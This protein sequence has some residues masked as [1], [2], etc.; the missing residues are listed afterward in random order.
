M[1]TIARHR[2]SVNLSFET[3]YAH[4]TRTCTPLHS[5]CHC[6]F[7]FQSS[8][9][10]AFSSLYAVCVSYRSCIVL[11]VLCCVRWLVVCAADDGKKKHAVVK[12]G[13]LGDPAVGKTSLS[14]K[15]I[16]GEFKQD[17]IQTL[18]T[19]A[20]ACH[21]TT[22]RSTA[23]DPLFFCVF[24]LYWLVLLACVVLFVLFDLGCCHCVLCC[25]GVLPQ[26]KT[27][28]LKN[29][30]ITFSVFDLGGTLRW[31]WPCRRCSHALFFMCLQCQAMNNF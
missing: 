2:H 15:Y 20:R 29:T 27:V 9:S 1:H 30:S 13:M 19:T 11:D 25:L 22:R 31:A 12:V 6:P 23:H 24:L 26:E 5:V 8:F 14:N 10:R 7:I 17:Y 4:H 21:G 18:G 28:E 3:I 16:E